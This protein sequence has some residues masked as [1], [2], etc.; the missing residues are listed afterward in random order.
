MQSVGMRSSTHIITWRRKHCSL[1]SRGRLEWR[2]SWTRTL[3]SIVG[4]ASFFINH[5]SGLNDS[6]D[7]FLPGFQ[8]YETYLSQCTVDPTNFSGAHLI[9]LIDGFGSTLVTH[10][11]DEIPTLISLNQYGSK[12]PL[13]DMI[14]AESQKSPLHISIT[15]GTPFFFRNLDVEFEDGLW[16]NW[17]PMPGLVWWIMQRTFVAWNSVSSFYPSHTAKNY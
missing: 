6:L 5:Q 10:L 12:L 16:K 4:A 7:A 17:P 9:R 11:S 3:I 1:R 14:N 2:V 8:A 15:G 13:L